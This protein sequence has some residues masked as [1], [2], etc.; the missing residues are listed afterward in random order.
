[1][2]AS[3]PPPRSTGSA[4]SSTVRGT[5]LDVAIYDA[6]LD[7]DD[8]DR[9]I[10]TL[11]A[12]E[13]RGVRVRAIYNDDHRDRPAA[14]SPPASPPAGPSLLARLAASVPATV[15]PGIPDLMHNKYMIRDGETVWTGSTN[16]TAD[17]WTHME[18]VI[19]VIPSADLAAA[20]TQDFEQLWERRHVEHTGTFD[21][22][23][24]HLDH[25][26]APL[27]VR[28]IFSPGRGRILGQLVARR[29]A[30][31]NRRLRICSPVITSGPILSTLAERLDDTSF[32]AKITVGPAADGAGASAV[33]QGSACQLED[34]ARTAHP[35]FLA[36]RGEAVAPVSRRAA[37]RLYARQDRCLRRHHVR[38]LVQPQPFG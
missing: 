8:C 36:C 17:A 7:D 33:G 3:S 16:W 32:D 10:A 28:A 37:A 30:E 31:A 19:V 22:A 1:M 9:L 5:S 14:L 4:R 2:G 6:H 13:A 23:P 12:A 25:N 15:I 34:P 11:D 26:G 18:N 27:A 35:G 20:F 29:I 21:D 24:A 38:G